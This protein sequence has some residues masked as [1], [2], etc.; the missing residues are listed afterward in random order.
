M[1]INVTSPLLPPLEEFIPY[2][3]DIWKRKWLTNNGFYHKEFEENLCK[4]LKISHIS[5]FTNGTLPLITA[6]Q[7][8]RI[9]GE[10]VTTPYSFAAT[11]H[12]LV[13][14]E[15]EPV[16]VDVDDWGNINPDRIEEAITPKTTA[17]LAVHV[18]G[19]PCD[20]EK[21]KVI[22][23]RYGLKLVYDAAHC[24]G[25]E[26]N[27]KSVLEYGDMATISFH[28]TKLFN[29]FE[30]GALVCR[31]KTEK[32]RID[33]LKNFG[34]AD[35]TKIIMPGI[36]GKIDEIRCAFGLLN[37]KYVDEAIKNRRK[38]AL[39][40]R[41]ILA[42]VEGISFL[43]D[44]E[45]VKHNYAYFPVFVDKAKY[46]VSRDDLYEKLKT[47]GIFAR[48]YFYPLI[49]DFLPYR[50]LKS[51]SHKNLPNA[52]KIASQVICLP[53]YADLDLNDVE[54]IAELIKEIKNG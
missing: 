46:G 43:G 30:G 35:E 18:Y 53:I 54:R 6:L 51:A 50:G 26:I 27:S 8:L 3:E 21:I 24:F 45:N 47:H 33:Y 16:F 19:N 22:A 29:T 40:Y 36:N 9:S 14:N 10:V 23:D 15:I 4:Y 44:K 52:V 1:A 28:A 11:A 25:V 2:L 31:S 49:S 5:L 32:E 20:T 13:W 42:D 12:S 37:L 7:S 48:R 39:K 41:E 34:F 38:C 17:I